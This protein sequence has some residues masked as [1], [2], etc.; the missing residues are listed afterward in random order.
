MTSSLKAAEKA[1]GLA[2]LGFTEADLG[3]HSLRSGAA[4]AMY[5]DELPVYT[6]MLKGHWS[7]DAFLRYIRKQVE[8]FSHN[9]SRRMINNMQYSHVP[10]NRSISNQD[11]LQRNNRNNSQTR[12]NMG[13]GATSFSRTLPDMSLW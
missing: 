5:L 4:M 8:Q 12:L 13:A 9:V 3:T 10:H 2:K 1:Y 11:P 6:I 7:S